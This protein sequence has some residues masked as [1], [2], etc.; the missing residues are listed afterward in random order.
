MTDYKS[1]LNLP[2]TGEALSLPYFRHARLQ[3]WVEQ[4]L[5]THPVDTA[6]AFSSPMAQY[7]PGDAAPAPLL[8]VLDLVDVDSEKWRGYAQAQPWPLAA[9]Y[10]R[11]AAKLLA[12]ERAMAHHCDHTLLVSSAEA[13]LFRRLAP[14]SGARIDYFNMGVDADYFSPRLRLPKVEHYSLCMTLLMHERLG[15]GHS[16]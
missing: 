11:E 4:T 5:A 8:R 9:L 12:H 7:L 3:R 15:G 6:I 10:R 13:A 16:S 2:A 14:E 1:T